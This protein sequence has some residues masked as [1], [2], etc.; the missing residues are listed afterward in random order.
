MCCW[1]CLED[2]EIMCAIDIEGAL[3]NYCGE[4]GKRIE[5]TFYGFK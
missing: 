3:F 1:I 2:K 5:A 4:C